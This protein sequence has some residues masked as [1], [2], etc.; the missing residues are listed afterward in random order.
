[1][2]ERAVAHVLEPVRLAAEHRRAD[3]LRAL[4]AHL[5]GAGGAVPREQRHAVA[6][7]AAAGDR[8]LGHHGRAVV[9]AARSRS[10]ACGR[11]GRPATVTIRARAGRRRAGSTCTSSR[12]RSAAGDD[13]DV[14]HAAGGDERGPPSGSRLPVTTGASAVPYSSDF[15]CSS[16]KA[17]FSST[18]TI[19]VSPSAN[20]RTIVGS[21][22][23]T[24][25]GLRTRMPSAS[26]SPKRDA[27]VGERGHDVAVGLARG[28][29]AEPGGDRDRARRRARRAARSGAPRRGGRR[30]P[31]PRAAST[32]ART[33]GRRGGRTTAGRRARSGGTS[34]IGRPTSTVA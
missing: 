22:G 23:Q 1:M 21:S 3:P 24:S 29:D 11:G 31:P 30:P 33:S 16:R 8:A 14:E 6:S 2:G 28:E 18:T 17:R 20:D 15:T 5:R 12:R 13:G 32:T 4:A 27:E 19:S 34:G 26:R 9:R 10:T 25:A 7:D